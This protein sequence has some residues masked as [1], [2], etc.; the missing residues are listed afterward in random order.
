MLKFNSSAEVSV[1]HIGT[2]RPVISDVALQ[3][4]NNDAK[5]EESVS[6]P[7]FEQVYHELTEP[8]VWCSG[9]SGI[10]YFFI[11]KSCLPGLTEKEESHREAVKSTDAPE[12]VADTAQ[13]CRRSTM[14]GRPAP[15][16]IH[17]SRL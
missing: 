7:L 16:T 10:L 12:P 17:I 8:S 15:K 13:G 9:E 11:E 4:S 14:L 1:Y 2:S 3:R 5:E 6:R